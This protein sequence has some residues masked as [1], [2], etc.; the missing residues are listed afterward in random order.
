MPVCGSRWTDSDRVLS[1]S[2]QWTVLRVRPLYLTE[3]ITVRDSAT[4]NQCA[5]ACPLKRFLGAQRSPLSGPGRLTLPQC[6]TTVGIPTHLR[7]ELES[8]RTARDQ[9]ETTRV[10]N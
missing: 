9:P 3:W 2:G 10:R 6:M 8:F 5:V 7:T 1:A 4:V